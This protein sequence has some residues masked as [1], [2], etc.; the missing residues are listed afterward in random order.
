MITTRT[1]GNN[2]YIRQIELSN[3]ECFGKEPTAIELEKDITCL[4]GNNGSGKSTVIKAVLR[5]FGNALEDR[6]IVKSDFHICPNETDADIKG[7][8]LYID[9]VF[10]FQNP[11]TA[12][13]FAFFASVIYEDSEKKICARMRL[14]ATWSNE[15]Y[16]DE[17]SSTMF[18]VLSENDIEFGD[19]SSLKMKV[20]THQRRLINLIYIPAT[21]DAKSILRNDM[22]RIIK[23][24]ERY[25]DVSDEKKEAIETDSKSLGKK[26]SN[27]QAIQSI[28]SVI[29]EIWQKAHDN[30]LQHYQDIKLEVV[31]SKFE[32]LIKSILLKLCPAE[33]SEAKDITE[34]SDGQVSL[35]YFALSMALYELEAMHTKQILKGIKEQD[36]E[37]PIFTILTFEEPENHLSPFYL[38]RIMSLLEEKSNNNNVVNLITSHSPNVV[39]R[40]KRVEQIRFLRQ[41]LIGDTE[42]KSIVNK[43]LLPDNKDNED[44][45]YINQA[46]L[47]HPELYFSKLVVLGEGDSEKIILPVISQK[48]GYDFD[49]SFVLFVPLGGRHVNHMWRLL[50]ELNIPHITLLDYD[51]GRHGG[52]DGRITEI[53]TKLDLPNTTTQEQLEEHTVYFS[54]PLDLDMTMITAFP[55]FYNDNGNNDTH[56][57]LVAAV[58]G[59]N[60]D[61]TTYIPPNTF[62]SDELLKKYR[63]LFKTKSK[64]ASHYLACDLIKNMNDHDFFAKRPEVLGKI[65]E[66]IREMLGIS[67]SEQETAYRSTWGKNL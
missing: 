2:M 34:L 57:E 26:V 12:E 52:G 49:S 38:S 48:S 65:V 43:I 45:K 10:E 60:G 66:K 6:T 62:F 50:Q 9:I 22:K 25:A 67:V 16:E 33:T 27:L 40:M 44:Y 61:E 7:K 47:A 8:Q 54:Y 41:E 56:E 31:P 64:V 58:L 59:K 51:C 21:R 13:I 23:K 55:E 19:E 35:L 11:A 4:I 5:M 36:Y 28:Q 18:W 42:R 30:T 20:E 63:Y 46:V 24:I 39:R 29:N 53:C 1:K 15:E 32:N 3:F 37:A 14:E 17:V